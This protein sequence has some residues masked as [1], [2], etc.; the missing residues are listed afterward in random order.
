MSRRMVDTRV[1]C[2]G[3]ATAYSVLRIPYWLFVTR[4]EPLRTAQYTTHNTE[5]AIRNTFYFPLRPPKVPRVFCGRINSTSEW[6][7]GMTW[8]ETSST[9]R[10]AAAAPASVAAFT[11]PTSPR[12]ITATN[13][14]PTYSLPI[15]V[16]LAALTMASAAS[17]APIRPLVST[18]PRAIIVTST[19]MSA[20]PYERIA[21]VGSWKLEA[22]RWKQEAGGQQ[23]DVTVFFQ[24]LASSFQP[25]AS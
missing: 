2:I 9:T 17:I 25:P 7:R 5:Y 12:T 10:L 14:P 15:S 18:I 20:S 3:S 13:P 22:G 16:T 24:L 11:A 4:D 6:G 1:G 23:S 19:G 21:D 8:T